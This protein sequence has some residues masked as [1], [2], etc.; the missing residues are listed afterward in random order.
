M[1]TIIESLNDKSLPYK[2]RFSL[3]KEGMK[4]KTT[5]VEEMDKITSIQHP[6]FPSIMLYKNEVG[7]TVALVPGITSTD[8]SLTIVEIDSE[9]CTFRATNDLWYTLELVDHF[10][11]E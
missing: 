9:D 1:S 6:F 11:E 8:E 3:I 2:E 4:F 10:E 5:T 7:T